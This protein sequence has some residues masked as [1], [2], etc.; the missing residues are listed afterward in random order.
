ML[1]DVLI[2]TTEEQLKHKQRGNVPDG[3]TPFWTVNGHP[4][5]T[6][7]GER[8]WFEA[9]GRLIATAEIVDVT[10]GRIWFEPLKQIDVEAPVDPP[11]RGFSYVDFNTAEVLGVNRDT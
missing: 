3:E 2:H 10:D 6:E 8:I 4:R 9:E 7:A 11:T 1:R 5:Q